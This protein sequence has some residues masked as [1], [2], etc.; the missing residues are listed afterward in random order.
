[1]GAASE[2]PAT[3]AITDCVLPGSNWVNYEVYS[4]WAN[5]T[6]RGSVALAIL[7]LEL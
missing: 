5:G 2:R 7:S 3:V 6:Y 1:M 4:A